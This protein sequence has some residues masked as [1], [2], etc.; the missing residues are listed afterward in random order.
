M[1]WLLRYAL[2]CGVPISRYNNPGAA[3]RE[4]IGS[5]AWRL[6]SRSGRDAFLPILRNRRFGFYALRAYADRLVEMGFQVAPAAHL[7]QHIIDLSYLYQDEP[8]DAPVAKRDLTLMR[9]AESAGKVSRREFALVHE[10]MIRTRPRIDARRSWRRLVLEAAAWRKKVEVDLSHAQDKPWDFVIDQIDIG[11]YRFVALKTPRDL[12][13]E[14]VAMGHCL[15]A[16]RCHCSSIRPS[17]FFSVRNGSAMVGT[18]ELQPQQQGNGWFLRDVRRSFNR[19][20]EPA[21]LLAAQEMASAYE[22]AALQWRQAA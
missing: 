11:D 16:L 7:V 6:I 10:W 3:L 17:R 15:Y 5:P 12:W 13:V 9:L 18:A 21:L 8:P 22:A 14:G 4:R 2:Y 1:E 19:L 20:P